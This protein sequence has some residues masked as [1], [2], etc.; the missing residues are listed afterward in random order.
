MQVMTLLQRKGR[1]VATIAP[2]ATVRQAVIELVRY[3]IGALVVLNPGRT[4]VGIVSERDIVR[5]LG[6]D[7]GATLDEPVSSLM[8]TEVH[9]C[10]GED[11][12]D[13]LMTT[14]TNERVRHIP[15]VSA[16][17]A[18]VGIVSIGD[19]VQTRMEELVQDRDALVSYINAR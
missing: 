4:I 8:S 14:M 5:A 16:E 15:V 1:F 12:V 18:L 3:D 6:R 11:E 13:S 17:S 2:E 19:V 10:T 9:T 7:G